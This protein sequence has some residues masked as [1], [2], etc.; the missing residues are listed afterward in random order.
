VG[1][2]HAPRGR[3]QPVLFLSLQFAHMVGR[4]ICTGRRDRYKRPS[5]FWLLISLS[6]PSHLHL[7]VNGH[8]R[9]L[10][11]IRLSSSSFHRICTRPRRGDF[12]RYNKSHPPP[13]PYPSNCRAFSLNEADDFSTGNVIIISPTMK[14]YPFFVFLSSPLFYS[15]NSIRFI[16]RVL[17]KLRYLPIPLEILFLF[18]VYYR[19]LVSSSTS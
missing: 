8:I 6:F 18:T 15:S 10:C 1:T 16:T 17:H 11:S 9:L 12:H 7:S 13:P 4:L 3:K 5:S 14:S 19:H 2:Y